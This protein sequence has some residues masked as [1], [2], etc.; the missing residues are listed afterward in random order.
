MMMIKSSQIIIEIIIFTHMLF[1]IFSIIKS[2]GF[3]FVHFPQVIENVCLQSYYSILFGNEIFCEEYWIL[4]FD[5]VQNRR[6]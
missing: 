6:S 4:K 3:V 5:V 1:S 2:K